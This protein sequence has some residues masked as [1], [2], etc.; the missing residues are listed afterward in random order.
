MIVGALTAAIGPLLV[1]GGVLISLIGSIVSTLGAASTAIAG[2]GGASAVLGSAFAALT[3]PIGLT[4]A[5]IG[6]L[7]IGTIAF[8]KHMSN[9]ALPSVE[10]FGK[11]VSESTKEALNGFFDLSESAS[12][13]VTNMY[14]T[15]TKVTSEMAAELTSKFDQMNTQIVEGM[16]KRNTEQLSDLQAFFL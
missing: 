2:A 7:T 4:V 11:G 9:D 6:G 14:V 13:S 5:A 3:G 1:I 10:R 15:S 12:Q 8:A 16:K